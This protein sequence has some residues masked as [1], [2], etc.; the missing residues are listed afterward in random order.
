MLRRIPWVVLSAA[1]GNVISQPTASDAPASSIDGVAAVDASIDAAV[2][3][4]PSLELAV[5][6]DIVWTSGGVP[7]DAG[8]AAQRAC[9]LQQV[10]GM[11]KAPEHFVHVD[12]VGAK[13]LVTGSAAPDQQTRVRCVT[14]GA[15]SGI[16][17]SPQ[18]SWTQGQAA[19]DLGPADDRLCGLTSVAG[20]YNGGGELVHT[21]VEGGRWVLRG[22]SSATGVSA[23]ARCLVFPTG[24]GVAFEGEAPRQ[25]P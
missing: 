14:Y 24:A 10:A 7:V 5:E 11:F 19:V 9:F 17:V 6:P 16:G 12:V 21:A 2:D 8:A 22:T 20:T 18:L 4:A 3:A 1:C 13:W 25:R 15:A 23:S